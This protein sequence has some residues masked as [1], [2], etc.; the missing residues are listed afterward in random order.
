VKSI[1]VIICVLFLFALT[2]KAQIIVPTANTTTT[3]SS[4]AKK[5]V[6]KTTHNKSS[7]NV[8]DRTNN[9]VGKANNGINKANNNVNKASATADST[10]STVGKLKKFGQKLISFIPKGSGSNMN[11]TVIR[12]TGGNFSTIRKLDDNVQACSGVKE[13]KM[14]FSSS[15]S[16]ITVTHR[17]TT[18]ALLKSLKRKSSD[19]FKDSNIDDFKEGKI[20]IK[21]M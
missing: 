21:L 9:A 2:S 19:I 4:T 6:K 18:E 15:T 10:V 1:I 16:T 14:K 7:G 13:T 11:T 20:S 17:G 5:T 12:V 3:N 8:L